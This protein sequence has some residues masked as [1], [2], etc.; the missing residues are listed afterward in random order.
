MDGMLMMVMTMMMIRMMISSSDLIFLFCLPS[1]KEK[2]KHGRLT[3]AYQIGGCAWDTKENG[4]F[5]G[6]R[7]TKHPGVKGGIRNRNMGGC[8]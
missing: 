4:G 8:I 5:E 6:H 2:W 1:R 7:D 3:L